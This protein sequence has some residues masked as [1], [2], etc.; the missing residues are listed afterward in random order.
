M[1]MVLEKIFSV[2]GEAEWSKGRWFAGEAVVQLRTVIKFYELLL[3]KRE[4][5][6]QSGGLNL[7]TRGRYISLKSMFSMIWDI[8]L[9]I[10]AYGVASSV[11]QVAKKVRWERNRMVIRPSAV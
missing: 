8:C 5:K 11:Q 7:W 3:K 4:E 9:D 10:L 1:M 2:D 6:V